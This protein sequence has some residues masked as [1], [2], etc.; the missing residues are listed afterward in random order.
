MNKHPFE[1]VVYILPNSLTMKNKRS[2][3]DGLRGGSEN[4]SYYLKIECLGHLT[5]RYQENKL[6][7]YSFLRKKN[8]C[9]RNGVVTNEVSGDG[10]KEA[11]DSFVF[12]KM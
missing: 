9:L 12:E 11:F 6:R 2:F 7:S 1:Q 5:E 4:L 10:M 8:Q 3:F